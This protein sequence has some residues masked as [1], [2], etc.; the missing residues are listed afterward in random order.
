MKIR[1]P[2]QEIK[3]TAIAKKKGN[4]PKTWDLMKILIAL[5]F[6]ECWE[7]WLRVRCQRDAIVAASFSLTY[8]PFLRSL[9]R[10]SSQFNPSGPGEEGQPWTGAGTAGR[11]NRCHQGFGGRIPSS[12]SGRGP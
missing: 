12:G 9:Q 7:A 11:R 10:F 4:A 8:R 1:F 5:S 6:C 3:M 2:E